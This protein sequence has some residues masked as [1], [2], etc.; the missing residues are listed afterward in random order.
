M[1]YFEMKNQEPTDRKIELGKLRKY[2]QEW[3]YEPLAEIITDIDFEDYDRLLTIM[4]P[5]S[6][7][8]VFRHL[9]EYCMSIN[10]DSMVSLFG[11]VNEELR[12]IINKEIQ[13][14]E[15]VEAYKSQKANDEAN[16]NK[17][18]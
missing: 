10:D 11:I 1:H 18:E 17:P 7:D 8:E 2:L 3:Y 9:F 14:D 13:L 5:S 16:Q 6:G 15:Q 4:D 12:G